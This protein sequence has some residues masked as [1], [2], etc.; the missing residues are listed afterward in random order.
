LQEAFV[1]EWCREEDPPA[2]E[3]KEDRKMSFLRRNFSVSSQLFRI[4][5][6]FSSDDQKQSDEAGAGLK[7]R[8]IP[9]EWQSGKLQCF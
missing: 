6:F 7:K 5:S 1:Y 4:T 8:A 9:R 3:E 2:S